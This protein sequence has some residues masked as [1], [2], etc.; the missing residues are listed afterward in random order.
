[1]HVYLNGQLDDG[2]AVGTV[3][4]SQRNSTATVNIGQRPTTT[5]FNFNGRI[6]DVRI[7]DRA[8]TQAEVLADM[9]TPVA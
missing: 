7:Y 2:A 3:T 4:A 8:L 1:M 5:A 9:N 6:D